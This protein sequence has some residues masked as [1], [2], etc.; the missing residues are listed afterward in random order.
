M[1][2]TIETSSEMRVLHRFLLLAA[3]MMPF[4][5]LTQTIAADPM[6]LASNKTN[7]HGRPNIVVIIADDWSWPHASI[8]GDSVV[9]T[10]NFDRIA[11][12]GV[13]FEN[14]FVSAPS[15]TS[16]RFA[17]AT[18]QYHWRLGDADSLGGSLAVGIPVYAE[19]LAESGY[20]TGFSRKGAVPS[21]HVYRG[22]DPFGVPFGNF[23]EFLLKRDARQPFCFWYGAGEPHR[24]YK[25]NAGSVEKRIEFGGLTVPGCLPDNETVRADLGDYYQR[26]ERLDR[27]AGEVLELLERSGEL[28]NTIVVMSSDNGMPFPR[29]K[30]TLYDMGTRVP[31]AIRWGTR[32]KAGRTVRDF[33]MPGDLAATFLDAT[34]LPVPADMTGRSLL[35]LLTAGRSG[36]IDGTRDHVLT[37]RERHVYDRPS[38]A[39]RTNDFLYIRNFSPNCWPTGAADGPPPNYDFSVT[40]WP[41]DPAAFSFDVDPSPTKQWMLQHADDSPESQRLYRLAF[42]KRPEEELYDLKTDSQQLNNV[43]DDDHY[44]AIRRKLSDQLTAELRNSRDPRF[45][46]PHHA[47]YDVNG[48]TVH[49]H[50]QLWQDESIDTK[51]M[52]VLLTEQLNRVVAAVPGKAL[53]ELR[54][55]PVWINPQYEGVRP[56]AEYHPGAGWLRNNGRNPDMV[57]AVEI[58][59]VSNF[60]FENR[61]MPYLM[62]HELAHAYHDRVLGFDQP[63]IM[64]A[65]EVAR[66]SGGYDAVQR[67]NGKTTV[68]D[69]AYAMSNHKEYFAESTEAYFGRNDF[70]PFNREELKS[71]D[72]GMHRLL[73]EVWGEMA[74]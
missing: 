11:K 30:A 28:E 19:L 36:V 66:D 52:F 45:A 72:V 73:Q 24:P 43:V 14:A 60:A 17:I 38:R 57:K 35:P 23:D 18:G 39:I 61:R 41:K 13:L 70:F 25:P 56:T 69:K 12:E 58:T 32:V 68:M 63:A 8:L 54:N 5:L 29:C 7:D 50:D 49:L 6:A 9:K 34:S 10:P 42:G 64:A 33:V 62:L 4:G 26:V 53:A 48:W 16:S 1:C 44:T 15:C 59:T 71:H 27:H 46:L 31:L 55:V 22:N 47:T 20:L 67:F 51:Q 21:Q 65:F 2:F 74:R 3:A 40:P 37:G